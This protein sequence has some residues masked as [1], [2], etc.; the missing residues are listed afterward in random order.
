MSSAA[1]P[2]SDSLSRAL[3]LADD[4][5]TNCHSQVPQSTKTSVRPRTHPAVC[6][7]LCLFRLRADGATAR[8]SSAHLAAVDRRQR[9]RAPRSPLA[10]DLIRKGVRFRVGVART[11][12]GSIELDVT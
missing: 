6:L 7:G 3:N 9:S 2:R 8:R 11:V 4:R 1:I 10:S 5:S 12:R